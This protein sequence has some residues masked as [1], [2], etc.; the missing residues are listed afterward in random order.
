MKAVKF[1]LDK[2]EFYLVLD[3]EA[4]FQI[5]DDF[6]SAT[7][8][9]EKM[10]NDTREGFS[11]TC[12]AAAI[13]AERGELIRRR[14]GYDPGNIPEADDFLHFLPPGRIIKLKEA[15]AKAIRI[16][17]AREIVEENEEYDEGLAEL[18]QKKTR[19]VGRNT[20]A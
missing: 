1:K 14:L 15:I 16:G 19:C 9:L 7:L 3:G 5:R 18:N 12:S 4:M 6:G 17:Y 8:L 13:L 2:E 11:A 20:T 10:E